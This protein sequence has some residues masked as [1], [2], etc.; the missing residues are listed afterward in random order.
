MVILDNYGH[1]GLFP[2]HWD[3]ENIM[4]EGWDVF[5]FN[6]DRWAGGGTKIYIKK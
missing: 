1:E 6:H 5:N 3:K 4:G 2:G